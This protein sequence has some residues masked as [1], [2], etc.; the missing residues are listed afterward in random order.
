M[1]I[2]F[3][4]LMSQITDQQLEESFKD[5]VEWKETGSLKNDSIIK[6]V[7]KEF[8]QTNYGDND[9]AAFSIQGM[10]NIFLFEIAK[11]YYN[12]KQSES[13]LNPTYNTKTA[14][15]YMRANPYYNVMTRFRDKHNYTFDYDGTM[16]VYKD[17]EW[18][19]CDGTNIG[20]GERWKLPIIEK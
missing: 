1:A 6:K 18:I 5:I 3:N 11:R 12:K 14:I 20:V 15:E 4:E 2:T 9:W 17:N 19:Y 7:W 16:R 8:N 10:E 13:Q